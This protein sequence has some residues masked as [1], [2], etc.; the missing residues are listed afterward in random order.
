MSN[1]PYDD[2]DI[3]SDP[4]MGCRGHS[5]PFEHDK[6]WVEAP[7]SMWT[8]E[9]E[10]KHMPIRDA[11][12]AELADTEKKRGSSEDETCPVDPLLANLD[13]TSEYISPEMQAKDFKEY[14]A[15]YHKHI[16]TDDESD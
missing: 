9:M 13:F 7:G 4:S 5:T 3:S 15:R 11:T 8:P 1:I 12:P 6:Y 2:E 10:H 16:E 14:L